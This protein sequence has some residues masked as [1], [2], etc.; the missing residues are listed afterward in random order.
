MTASR[1]RERVHVR[2]W[3]TRRWLS[4]AAVM[5]L[6]GV[7]MGVPTGI[8]RTGLY[9]RMT[10]VLWWNYPTW[11]V[12]A[13]LIGL[14]AATYV[15]RPTS[16]RAPLTG[17]LLSTLAIGCPVCNKLVVG[18]VGIS[19]ALHLWAPV[20]PWL[21]VTSLLLLGYALRRRLASEIA[22]PAASSATG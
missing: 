1:Q 16:A 22:C 3:P 18:A 11:A 20:Q 15:A 19:G 6:A 2:D 10:P 5:V 8:I 13:L 21:G 12:S 4:A 17:G 9:H 14:L 7:M